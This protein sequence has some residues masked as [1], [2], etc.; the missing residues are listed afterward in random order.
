MNKKI[1]QLEDDLIKALNGS[2]IPIEAKRIVV[3]NVY[4]I[5]QR[6]SDK[7]ILLEIRNAEPVFE[8]GELDNAESS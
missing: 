1:R 3:L 2:D 6:E 8:K 4:N 7:A 5:V